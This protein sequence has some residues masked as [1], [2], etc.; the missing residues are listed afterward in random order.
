MVEA[1]A[2]FDDFKTWPNGDLEMVG[3]GGTTLSG[4][5]KARVALARAV[6]QVLNRFILIG[7][8]FLFPANDRFFRLFYL[9]NVDL[10][11]LDDILSAVDA[12]VA[13]HIYE[14]CIRGLL[15]GKTRVFVTHATK[16]FASADWLIVLE[17]GRI[18]NQGANRFRD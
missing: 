2:L 13:R 4:G 18:V 14:K 11:L 16:W 5:Q 15:E 17:N 6:Y 7:P 12:H 8:W 3:E 9:K 10:Y 1:C